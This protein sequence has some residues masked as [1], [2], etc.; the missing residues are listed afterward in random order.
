MQ[1]CF[2]PGLASLPVSAGVTAPASATSESSANGDL[3]AVSSP[4]GGENG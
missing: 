4:D 1:R 2:R 3:G